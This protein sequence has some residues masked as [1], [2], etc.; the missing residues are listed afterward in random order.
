MTRRRSAVAGPTGLAMAVT[1]STTLP[2]ALLGAVGGAAGRDLGFGATVLGLIAAGFW[3][4][5]W[6]ASL[7]CGG[8]VQRLGS[9]ATMSLA[10]GLALL[11]LLGS[12]LLT[13]GWPALVGWAAVGGVAN[14]LGHPAS[15]SWLFHRVTRRRALAFGLKQAAVPMSSTVTGLSI[16]VLVTTAG[17]RTA[18][19][20]AVVVA[21]LV[22]GWART[23]G[24]APDRTERAARTGGAAGSGPPR[25]LRVIACC[26]F[27]G[28]AHAN[29][30]VVFAVTG[31]T[32]RHVSP[33]VAGALLTVSSIAAAV[34]R[35]GVGH[36]A[37]RGAGGSFVTVAGLLG[38][39]ACGLLAMASTNPRI[40]VAGCLLA[41]FGSF[42]WPGLVHFIVARTSGTE[43]ARATMVT[44]G[45]S[46]L[47]SMV[48]PLALGVAFARLGPSTPWLL[49]ATMALLAMACA[50]AAHAMRPVLVAA[51]G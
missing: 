21:A 18:Y 40:F 3:A 36:L 51:T 39:G 5:S 8:L 35:V 32:A 1:M 17:W 10:G 26:T 33:Q 16:P 9:S 46:Y 31:A 42:G 15:N 37:D 44:Q 25:Y 41:F 12:A 24:G 38:T 48:G 6:V 28:A 19:A 7:C 29:T 20:P 30:M 23:A 4:A 11:S 45:G 47:G 13:P 2:V 50:L 43:V 22:C 34:S 49:M 14:A 27:F